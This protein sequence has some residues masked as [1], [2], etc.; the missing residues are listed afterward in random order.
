[1]SRRSTLRARRR[2]TA[3]AS[4]RQ[5]PFCRYENPYPPFEILSADRVE[6]IH[7]A[8][9]EILES[10]GVNFLLDEARRVLKAAEPPAPTSIPTAP[11]FVSSAA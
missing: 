10:I 1:M 11:G 8:S 6:A 4:L 9:L 2:Q 3:G 5:S 7:E